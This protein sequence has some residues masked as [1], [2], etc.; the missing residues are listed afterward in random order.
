[1][2]IFRTLAAMLL[3]SSSVV[4]ADDAG[5][6]SVATSAAAV[7][8]SGTASAVLP[9]SAL[10]HNSRAIVLVIGVAAVL[11]TFQRALSAP[12]KSA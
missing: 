8:A 7:G 2:C 1:M 5:G 11:V 12:R 4:L 9:A 3:L 10:P 6:V